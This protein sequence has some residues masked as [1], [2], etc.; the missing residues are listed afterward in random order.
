LS[1]ATVIR[2][3]LQ[4]SVRLYDEL[5]AS[6][7]ESAL[8]RNLPDLPSNRIGSQLWCV[9]GARE[10]YAR[11]LEAGEWSGFTCSL[12]AEGSRRI[13][14]VREALTRSGGLVLG[15]AADADSFNDDRARLL[16]DLLEHEATHHGQLI[17]YLY[18]LDLP[19]PAGWK[20][21]YALHD[22]KRS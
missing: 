17:R 19:I 4:R 11:A 22:R 8:S 3:R 9:V 2:D 16:V 18:A 7:P 1:L 15:A 20:K 5:A 14:D 10:S 6:L 13:A 21:R 12:D